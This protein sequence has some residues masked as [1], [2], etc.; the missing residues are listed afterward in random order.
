MSER[1][2]EKLSMGDDVINKNIL[3]GLIQGIEKDADNIAKDEQLIR[4]A[5]Q[6][7][8]RIVPE[9]EQEY[10]NTITAS[11]LENIRQLREKAAL[12]RKMEW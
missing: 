1:G 2:L 7:L 12:L 5:I 10:L 9:K 8:G 6:P 4:D 11:L 3:N